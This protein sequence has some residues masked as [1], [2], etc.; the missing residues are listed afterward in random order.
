MD[1]FNIKY[2]SAKTFIKRKKFK[3]KLINKH[4]P[5]DKKSENT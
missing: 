2:C 4:K 3:I 1:F 5:Q